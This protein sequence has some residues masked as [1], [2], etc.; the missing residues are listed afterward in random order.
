MSSA[1]KS[2]M[3]SMEKGMFEGLIDALANKHSQLDLNFQNV[4]VRMP[5]MEQIGVQLNGTITLAVHM[6]ELTDEEKRALSAKN[7]ALRS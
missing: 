1:K 7:V 4:S 2:D 6:R 5:G 3:V